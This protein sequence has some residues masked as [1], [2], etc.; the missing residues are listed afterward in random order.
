MVQGTVG[1][2]YCRYEGEKSQGLLEES[3]VNWASRLNQALRGER[4][5]ESEVKS[6]RVSQKTKRARKNVVKMA[7]LHRDHKLAEGKP[8]PGRKRFRGGSAGRSHGD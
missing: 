5:Q 6:P 7:E 3:R 1:E 2:L 8:S 4:R